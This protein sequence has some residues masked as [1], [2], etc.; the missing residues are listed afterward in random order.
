TAAALVR[1]RCRSLL[2]VRMDSSRQWG[3]ALISVLLVFSACRERRAVGDS[4]GR[5]APR[6]AER[7]RAGMAR[8]PTWLAGDDGQWLRPAKD[9]AST[10]FSSLDQIDV[11]NA[12]NLRLAFTLSTGLSKGHEAAPIVVGSTMYIVTPFPN[13]LYALRLEKSAATLK[14]TYKPNPDLAAQDVACCDVVNRGAVY[15]DG[16]I[17]FN[18]LD[19]QTIA[20]DAVDGKEVWKTRT[21]DLRQGESITMAPLVVDGKVL[22]GNSGDEFG[23]RGKLTALDLADGKVAWTAWSTGPDRDVLL[24]SRFHPFYAADRSQKLGVTSW[25]PDGWKIGGGTVWGWI[26]YDPVLNLLYYGTSGAAPWN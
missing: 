3:T 13:Y 5:S 2:S 24:G 9:Y 20:L 17:V 15:A 12:A 4:L 14:W 22:V 10:R 25:P 7:G 21:G 8:I 6:A 16:K 19:N 18:T 23:V 26:S 1:S 11:G